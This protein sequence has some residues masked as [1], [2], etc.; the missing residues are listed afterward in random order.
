MPPAAATRD[1]MDSKYELASPS[2]VM[3]ATISLGSLRPSSR[4]VML[5][6]AASALARERRASTMVAVWRGRA[7]VAGA[8]SVKALGLLQ[9]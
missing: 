6:G 4:C 1:R 8:W 9:R 3:A 7:P 2:L 5:P